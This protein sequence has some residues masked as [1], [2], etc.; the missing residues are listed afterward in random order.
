MLQQ[1]YPFISMRKRQRNFGMA[2]YRNSRLGGITLRKGL[3]KK[4]LDGSAGGHL[5]GSPCLL[6]I[7]F[8]NLSIKS[9]KS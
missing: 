7:D 3:P 8:V 2:S 1:L 6:K 5:K 9:F 4:S